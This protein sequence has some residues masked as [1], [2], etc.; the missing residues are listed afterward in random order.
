MAKAVCLSTV[1]SVIKTP[2]N[3]LSGSPCNADCHASCTVGRKAMPQ[4][5]VCFMMAKQAV[6]VSSPPPLEGT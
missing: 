5:L 1:E 4:T 6:A 2:P 3:A